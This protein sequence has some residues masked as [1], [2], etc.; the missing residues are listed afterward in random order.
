LADSLPI[1]DFPTCFMKLTYAFFLRKRRISSFFRLFYFWPGEG[2]RSGIGTNSN[3]LSSKMEPSAP[4]PFI[5][6]DAEQERFHP[7]FSV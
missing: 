6:T 4:A 5:D 3:E 2:N 1:F 7:M